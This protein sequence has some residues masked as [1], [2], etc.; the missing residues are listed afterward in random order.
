MELEKKYVKP[1]VS[2]RFQKLCVTIKKGELIATIKQ[3]KKNRLE[4][5]KKKLVNEYPKLSLSTN[6]ALEKIFSKKI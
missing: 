4:D 5:R 6:V 3:D 1:P 2:K